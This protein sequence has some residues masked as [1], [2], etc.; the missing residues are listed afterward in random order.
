M[1]PRKIA[2]HTLGCKLNFSETSTISRQF[3]N[4]GFIQVA[5][6]EVAD[7]YVINSC[8]VTNNAEK[9]CKSLIRQVM[10][11]NPDASVT[12]IGCYSQISPEELSAIPGVALVLG[13]ADKFNLL[14]HIQ[15]LD[16]DKKAGMAIQGSLNGPSEAIGD[17]FKKY[18]P[19]QTHDPN[20]KRDPGVDADESSD[21]QTSTQSSTSVRSLKNE[22]FIPSWSMD[23]R[24]R[25]FF[26]IQD[27]CD[28]FCT[29]CTIPLARG[30]SR[31]DTIAATIR[32]ARQI[33]G[34][35]TKEIVLSGVNIGDFGKLHQ[36]SLYDL[37]KELIT[38]DGIDR[39]RISS[40]EPDLL[41]D[42]IIELVAEHPRLM[43]HFHIPLQSGSDEVLKAMG[44]RYDTSLF[45]NRIETIRK[46]IPHACIAVDLIV[47]FPNETEALFK[48]SYEFIKQA[49]VSYI[50]V[51]TYSERDNTRALN[52]ANHIPVAERHNRSQQMHSLSE[53]KKNYFYLSNKGRKEK[54]LWENDMKDNYLYGFT[55]N[56]IRAK[57]KYD[58][59]LINTIQSVMLNHLDNDGVYII[60]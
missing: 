11:N 50:H 55:E 52:L 32:S 45:F 16:R 14:E 26:K 34:T 18:N 13:N 60:A 41:H 5:F 31:S 25:S 23:G 8:S 51:F 40:I 48:E 35:N 36:E 53:Q 58:P 17:P 20:Q 10:R 27:G 24:T 47:G 46:H 21:Q 1:E 57:T 37:L 28:Y 12:V 44:R 9:R 4:D 3:E 59:A 54:I 30:H 42:R 2:F 33:A 49:D 29:Y 22:R 56:Y 38:V 7:I 6:S 19:K 43:P 39:I 15:Q